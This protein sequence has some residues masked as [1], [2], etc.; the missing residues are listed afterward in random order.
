MIIGHKHYFII[1]NYICLNIG[2]KSNFKKWKKPAPNK[3]N[4]EEQSLLCI[5]EILVSMKLIKIILDPKL[6]L[7]N[8]VVK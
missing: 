3:Q 5:S 2:E 8:D 1:I 4:R 7:G 6:F